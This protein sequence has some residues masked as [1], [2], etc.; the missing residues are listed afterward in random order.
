[1][2]NIMQ[3]NGE[4]VGALGSSMYASNASVLRCADLS[5]AV[6]D[7]PDKV[8]VGSTLPSRRE[9]RLNNTICSLGCELRVDSLQSIS[10][11]VRLI[12]EGRRMLHVWLGLY[13]YFFTIYNCRQSILFGFFSQVCCGLTILIG[14]L[15]DIPIVLT[16]MCCFWLCCFQIPLLLFPIL[17]TP[18]EAQ[19]MSRLRVPQKRFVNDEIVI[20]RSRILFILLIRCIPIAASTVVIFIWALLE[21][22]PEA[23]KDV[24]K[25]ILCTFSSFISLLCFVWKFCTLRCFL[26]LL[27][28]KKYIFST[29]HGEH[30]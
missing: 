4:V 2:I 21:L 23:S 15:F 14:Q 29:I 1:M 24:L 9:L 3:Q 30:H 18:V 7:D 26:F 20:K 22:S 11:I 10:V 12:K 17:F 28:K 6:Y 13:K 19:A 5:I 27:T 25:H 16:P 8:N